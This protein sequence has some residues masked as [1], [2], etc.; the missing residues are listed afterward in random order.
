VQVVH[1]GSSAGA[2]IDPALRLIEGARRH[3]V[4]VM[5]DVYPY[6]AGSTDIGSAVF[7]EG[8]QQRMGGIDFADVELVSTG[9]RLTAERFAGLRA[10][11]PGTSVILHF[12]PE[13]AVRTALRHPL[14]MIGSDDFIENGQGH[15]RGAGTFARV[16]GR[17]VR[18]QRVLTLPQAIAKMTIMPARRLE[19]STPGMRRKGRLSVGA[20]AD[21][22]V[23][24]P[25]RV[26][27]RATYARPAQTSAGIVHVLVNGESVVADGVLDE[28]AR[29]GRPLRGAGTLTDR[30]GSPPDRARGGTRQESRP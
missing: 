20:D 5:A 22:V 11:Q 23:F 9:E 19:R 8:W 17:Y 2:V 7:S 12:I 16:L 15:P 4:D 27:D 3:G 13:E 25:A 6:T 24:D 14:V 28:A 10:T 26:V 30:R 29:P 1:I 21:V 18:E